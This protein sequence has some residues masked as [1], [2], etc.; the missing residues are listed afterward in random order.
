MARGGDSHVTVVVV[1]QVYGAI[2]STDS[3][4]D[5]V[6]AIISGLR[7]VFQDQDVPWPVW[8]VSPRNMDK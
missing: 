1:G 4:L 2:S 8:E 6:V 5:G 3:Y 7:V